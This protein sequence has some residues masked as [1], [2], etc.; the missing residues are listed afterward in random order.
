LK[1]ESTNLNKAYL[2]KQE[3]SKSWK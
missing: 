3:K 1:A 2:I